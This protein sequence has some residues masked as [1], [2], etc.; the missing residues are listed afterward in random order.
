MREKPSRAGKYTARFVVEET[1]NYVGTF[2]DVDFEILPGVG[3]F[4]ETQTTPVPVPYVWLEKYLVKYGKGDYETAGHAKGE[5]DVSLWES[6]V[7]GLDPEAAKSKFMAKIG[8]GVDG[9]AVVTWTP[10]LSKDE[11][12]RKYTTMGKEKLGDE[13]WSPVTD[14]NKAK[15]RFFK[16]TVEM[17]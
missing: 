3:G 9:K 11:K 10:D 4:T 6:Y 15:M 2:R 8:M 14:A 7:A 1:E 13:A 5:N 17:K 16:V 12:P